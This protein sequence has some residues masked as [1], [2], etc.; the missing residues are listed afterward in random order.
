MGLTHFVCW[1]FT[2]LLHGTI[3]A[4]TL[5]LNQIG[6]IHTQTIYSTYFPTQEWSWDF[7][8][9]HTEYSYWSEIVPVHECVLIPDPYQYTR[10]LHA[11]RAQIFF[12]LHPHT[13]RINEVQHAVTTDLLLLYERTNA[14][15][16][17][18]LVHFWGLLD[19][20]TSAAWAGATTTRPKQLV[21]SPNMQGWPVAS[22]IKNK[23]KIVSPHTKCG[24]PPHSTSVCLS[25]SA[26]KTRST[27]HWRS[28][29]SLMDSVCP[30]R[31]NAEV[32]SV[33]QVARR[34]QV[35]VLSWVPWAR[36]L[37]P[38]PA[39]YPATSH[40]SLSL[41]GGADGSLWWSLPPDPTELKLFLV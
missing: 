26:T 22:H 5:Q 15:P 3:R 35:T 36:I 37:R 7:L 38:R 20:F 16:W 24:L 9:C 29:A 30:C 8:L 1:M 23:W 19:G 18:S 17:R 10:F 13:K 31:H 28:D 14:L 27:E 4:K 32:D 41:H 6:T 33:H 2:R 40:A 12:N 21:Q 39:G 34:K 25:L 11:Q